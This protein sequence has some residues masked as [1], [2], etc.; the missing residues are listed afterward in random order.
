MILTGD[1]A[2]LFLQ[3]ADT[4]WG[5][6]SFDM[7][8]G[9][10][11]LLIFMA[12]AQSPPAA[13]DTEAFRGL[14]EK[15]KSGVLEIF[16][17]TGDSREISRPVSDHASRDSIVLFD[18]DQAVH[19]L[20]GAGP[21]EAL[22]ILVDPML[23]IR[24]VLPDSPDVANHL[25]KWLDKPPRFQN[26]PIPAL[27]LDNVLEP[28]FCQTLISYYHSQPQNFSGI[29]TRDS[30]GTAIQTVS[31]SFKRRHDCVLRDKT[32]VQGLQARIIRRVVPEIRKSF[33]CT[34]TGMDRMIIGCYDAA[35]LGGFGPHRDNTVKGAFHRLFAISLNL[36]H[37]FKGG[38]LI[39]P[40]FS[41]QGF[42]PPTG[43]ALIFSSALMH[44]VCPVTEGKRYACLP[45]AFNEDS[46][47]YA[48]SQEEVTGQKT[49]DAK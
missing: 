45:F 43:G 38:E 39:F 12:S 22:W 33:Q 29:L 14:A 31:Q 25:N 48:R 11:S 16:R 23:R 44:A 13:C 6:Y 35:E 32:L 10:Y 49:S 28:E 7:A 30:D 24:Q 18:D 26:G 9:R 19:R 36:N 27:M 20:Y 40:E 21:D 1:P 4:G 41:D 5:H 34:V 17:V 37:D 8:A 2:P 47:A 3:K 46:L 42:C 15:R